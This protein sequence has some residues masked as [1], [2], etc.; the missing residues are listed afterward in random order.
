M[1][2][3]GWFSRRLLSP[4]LAIPSMIGDEQKRR[5]ILNRVLM[6]FEALGT[7]FYTA[8]GLLERRLGTD[9]RRNRQPRPSNTNF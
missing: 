9:T 1:I 5:E 6:E 7:S 8:A 4:I 2:D 3:D